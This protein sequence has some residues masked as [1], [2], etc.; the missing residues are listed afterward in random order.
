[1]AILRTLPEAHMPF[2]FNEDGRVQ[3]LFTQSERVV[4]PTVDLATVSALFRVPWLTDARYDAARAKIAASN[5]VASYA[6]WKTFRLDP[7]TGDPVPVVWPESTPNTV[8]CSPIMLP[9]GAHQFVATLNRRSIPTN[10]PQEMELPQWA[11]LP[12]GWSAPGHDVWGIDNFAP[13]FGW[14]SGT[15]TLSK[16]RIDGIGDKGRLYRLIPV[17]DRPG[18]TLVT[19]LCPPDTGRSF[20]VTLGDEPTIQE[21]HVDGEPVYKCS[22]L[23]TLCAFAK[24]RPGSVF[25]DIAISDSF[26]LSA[27]VGV[28]LAHEATTVMPGGIDMV[29]NFGA[30]AMAWVASGFQIVP[31][32]TFTARLAICAA[33]PFWKPRAR[34][35]LGKC[36]KCG[37]TKLKHWLATERCPDK[38]W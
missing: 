21:I 7:L 25:R 14:Q 18:T 37:C 27:P 31:K 38:R 33:C 29:R 8:E 15:D 22:I 30:A 9:G 17:G 36:D 5:P 20:L 10:G 35:S 32:E 16:V 6:L 1:M 3:M 28:T 4:T 19:T 2:L 12:F 26:T 11:T 34:F 23:G 13:S 24:R